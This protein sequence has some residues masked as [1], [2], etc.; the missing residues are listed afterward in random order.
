MKKIFFLIAIITILLSSCENA[1][2]IIQDG[3]VNDEKTFTSTA[4]MNLY[5][6][7]TYDKLSTGGATLINAGTNTFNNIGVS[8][9]LTDEVGV[10]R[11]GSATELYRFTVATNNDYSRFIWID[12]YQVINYCNRILRGSTLV[13]PT[14]TADRVLYNSILAQTR[15]LRAFSHLQLLTYF[16]PNMKDDA[17]IGVVKMDRVP[18]ILEKLP[19]NSN[20]EVFELIEADLD[21]AAL[22]IAPVVAARP[23]TY[24]T[25]PMINAT[26]ARMYAYRGNYVK[27]EQF[28]DAVI[29][30]SN[31]VLTDG[32]VYTTSGAFYAN[33]S[34]NAYKQMFQDV[35]R[36]EVIW[37]IGRAIG[38]SSISSVF[39]VNASNTAGVT[40][41]DMN[42]SL[43]NILD[44][45]GTPWDIRRRVNIDP[46]AVINPTYTLGVNYQISDNLCIDKYSGI[47]GA[48]LVNDI[49]AFRLSE[50]FLIKAEAR[51]QAG[52][53]LTV[54]TI[55]KNIRDKRSYTGARPLPVY[56]SPTE[57]WA[58]ILLERR[59]ELCFEGHRYIDLKRLGAL[60]NKSIERDPLDCSTFN[61]S[62]C[63]F[64]V[65][66]YRFTL[67]IPLREI[68]GNP[69]IAQNP[70]Y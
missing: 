61:L 36:G 44:N 39:N 9:I 59:V 7:E 2:D 53:L 48:Q 30:N 17:A 54:A 37:S 3:E 28:A 64:P 56:A 65:T 69:T 22:N 42:R 58:D 55:L 47:T 38:K 66:D 31:L 63:G 50:M 35:I 25:L 60:A 40:T 43:F 14:S 29:S 49:K 11:G 52:A 62:L 32:T 8:A 51:A 41:F 12:N 27:A 19:R 70:G 33:T 23:W 4:Q 1:T 5:L 15:A 67:P 24:V 21:F 20:K 57:A 45:S 6:E 68:A 10:G 13:T 16:S 18:T 46:T 26:R 34:N